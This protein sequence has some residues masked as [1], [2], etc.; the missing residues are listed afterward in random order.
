MEG[1][2]PDVWYSDSL[3]SLQ[4][5]DTV[6]FPQARTLLL[7]AEIIV[8]CIQWVIQ[9]KPRPDDR[10]HPNPFLRALKRIIDPTHVEILG[11]IN[12]LAS[13]SGKLREIGLHRVDACAEEM[14][15]DLAMDWKLE[16]VV[17]HEVTNERLMLRSGVINVFHFV[18][19]TAKQDA[20]TVTSR[21][22]DMREAKVKIQDS[23]TEVI[24]VGV[25]VLKPPHMPRG[26]D[27]TNHTP[28]L[29]HETQGGGADWR[30]ETRGVS[31]LG[32]A[33]SD[34][35]V[36]SMVEVAAQNQIRELVLRACDGY[37]PVDKTQ[38]DQTQW[39]TSSLAMSPTVS[40]STMT[41]TGRC[42]CYTTTPKA[43]LV[44]DDRTMG[45]LV[46]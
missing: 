43:D 24:L 5:W 39:F 25:G 34:T 10:T 2:V 12:K 23:R 7:H 38:A 28:A 20:M 33:V 14:L 42:T 44:V 46:S 32:T 8:A 35:G 30:Q 27:I 19:S 31:F 4:P 18:S 9:N 21:A 6:L 26:D 36:A 11:G 1:F 17:W 22:R 41:S 15:R 29:S 13:W 16:L 45:Q 37:R 40:M 3:I